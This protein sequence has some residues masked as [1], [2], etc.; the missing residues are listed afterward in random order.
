MTMGMKFARQGLPDISDVSLGLAPL[1]LED[2][3]LS[4][5]CH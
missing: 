1:D 4:E 2:R 3:L 5:V